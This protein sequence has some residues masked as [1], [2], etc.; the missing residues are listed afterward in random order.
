MLA[1]DS[2]ADYEHEI[3]IKSK[4]SPNFEKSFVEYANVQTRI[5]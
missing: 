2:S 4:A 1:E 3:E 5:Y